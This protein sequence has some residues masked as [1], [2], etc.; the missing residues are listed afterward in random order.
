[1]TREDIKKAFE[2]EFSNLSKKF[3]VDDC[4]L[5]DKAK[6]VSVPKR[7]GVY[8]FWKENKVIKVGRHLTNARTRALQHIRDNTDGKMEKYYGDS[9]CHLLLYTI[10]DTERDRHWVKALE[11]YFE[12]NLNP[13]IPSKRS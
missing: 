12:R 5:S 8:V 4:V 6:L 9:S 10:K 13:L 1:M 3:D 2:N 7:A 11:Y